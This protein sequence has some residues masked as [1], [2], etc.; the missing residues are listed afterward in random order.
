MTVSSPLQVDEPASRRTRWMQWLSIVALVYMLLVAVSVIGGGFKL[1]AGE[2][3]RSLFEFAS[4]P[5]AGLVIGT[6]ATALIQSSSTV[7]SIIVGLVAGG[8][9]VTIAIPMVMGANIGTTITN[10]IV[11]LGHLKEGEEF[12]RAFAAATIHD[13]FNVVSVLIFL[14]LEVAFGVLDRIGGFLANLML[15]G[16]SMSMKGLNFVKPLVKPSVEI[17]E[18]TLGGFGSTAGGVSMI[19]IGIVL[20]FV[21]ITVI[22]KL[23]KILMVG[24]A[25]QILHAAIGHGPVTGIG[26]GT[27]ITVLVQSS[28]TTTSLIVPLV[29]TGVFSL[30][31]IYPFTL[32]ANIGTCITGLLAAT[33]ITG[34]NAV[35]AL[36]IALIHLLYNVIGVVVIYGTPIL[37]ELPVMAAEKLAEATIRNRL[38]AAAY[39]VSVFFLIPSV[40][41]LGSRLFG[42]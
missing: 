15:G 13:F 2:Q 10:T 33:A 29:G 12:R 38:Y 6:V 14:P 36:Q 1:A 26:T 11:S 4:N 27:A 28:S 21:S 32:G 7:T 25:K 35:L 18:Q 42:I 31:Q 23:L 5:I 40:I 17:F 39:I 19:A 16:D 22:G 41:V 20:I 30:R 8:L 34:A 9:P 24:R 37:R 3:A